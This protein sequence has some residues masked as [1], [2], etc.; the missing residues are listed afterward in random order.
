M[1]PACRYNNLHTA[2]PAAP[3]ESLLILNLAHNE[4]GTVVDARGHKWTQLAVLNLSFNARQSL[5]SS[6]GT[7]TRLQQLYVANNQLEALPESLGALPLVDL[8][9]S[10]NRLRCAST[11]GLRNILA[12]RV[13]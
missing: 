2:A 11:A 7:A 3:V 4:L 6:L 12:R 10:E 9:L 8:F 13:L 1:F 5:P